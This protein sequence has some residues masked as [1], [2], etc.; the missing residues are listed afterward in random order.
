MTPGLGEGDSLFSGSG[1]PSTLSFIDSDLNIVH[2]R[3]RKFNMVDERPL[4]LLVDTIDHPLLDPITQKRPLEARSLILSHVSNFKF[5]MKEKPTTNVLP[6][7]VLL[8]PK[9]CLDKAS[10]VKSKIE[11]YR[12]FVLGG[13]LSSCQERA[14]C[15]VSF[16]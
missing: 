13:T 4:I 12:Y 5:Q 15:R 10:F 9:F 14:M 16:C 7:L 8:D 6:L 1:A 11:S 3:T 2:E